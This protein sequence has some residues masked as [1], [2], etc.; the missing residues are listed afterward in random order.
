[1][2]PWPFRAIERHGEAIAL[3]NGRRRGYSPA[4]KPPRFL[5]RG[6]AS[7]TPPPVYSL[8][9]L[10]PDLFATTPLPISAGILQCRATEA[11]SDFA[12]R[13][14]PG[15]DAQADRICHGIVCSTRRR[16]RCLGAEVG[17]A[18]DLVPLSLFS[19]CCRQTHVRVGCTATSS[20]CAAV[21]FS[22]RRFSCLMGGKSCQ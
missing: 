11:Q 15:P 1:M 2:P 5:R 13:L 21:G 9:V 17:W 16:Q 18:R 7:S 8:P 4:V 14:G 6:L 10:V 22:A 20:C 3:S 19:V 12:C